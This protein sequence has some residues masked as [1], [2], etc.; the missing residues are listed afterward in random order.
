[1]IQQC[2]KCGLVS[3]PAAQ[4]CDRGYDFA[5]KAMRGWYLSPEGQADLPGRRLTAVDCLIGLFLPGI[6]LLVGLIRLVRQRPTAGPMLRRS[7]ASLFAWTLLRVLAC[8]LTPR[9]GSLS[10]DARGICRDWL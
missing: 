2:P 7:V 10:Q 8:A 9:P 4:R 5:A 1:M 3:P 6:G